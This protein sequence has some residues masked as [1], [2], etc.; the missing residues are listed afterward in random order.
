MYDVSSELIQKI[1]SDALIDTAYEWLC[2]RRKDY[3][4]NDDVCDIRFRWAEFKPHLQKR[5]LAGEYAISSQIVINTP[6]RRTELWSAKDALV[7]KA[8]SIVLGEHLKPMLSHNCYH[9]ADNGGAKAAVRATA[10]HLKQRQY[11]MKS[12]VKN[13][14]ASID[15]EI[16]FNLLQEYVPGRLVQKLLWQYIRRTV[17]CDGFYRDVKR[18]ISL[19]CPV[20]PLMGALYLKQLDDR[21]EKTGLFYARYMDDWIVIAPTRWKLRSAVKDY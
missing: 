18:G 3:S 11:V 7:L 21:M 9:L 1:A 16:L 14:Y 8:I 13:Y 17:Y 6:N 12:D 20:S 2:K 4:H 10:R 15:H 19:G 5:L